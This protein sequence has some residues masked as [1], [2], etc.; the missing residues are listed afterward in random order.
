MS[1]TI[2][3][4]SKKF[5]DVDALSNI[6]LN[7]QQGELAALVGPSGCGKTTLL[8][9]IAGLEE[10]SSGKIIINDTVVYAGNVLEGEVSHRR[11]N[12]PISLPTQ[13][14]NLGM[15][16]QDFALWPHLTVFENVAFGLRA[17]KQTQNLD[18]RVSDALEQV[19]L[20]QFSQRFPSQLSGGQQQRVSI[21][22]AIVIQPQLIL[23]DEPLSALDAVLKD[24]IQQLLVALLKEHQL[25]AVYVTHDQAEAMSMADKVMILNQGKVEQF[26]RPEAIYHKPATEFVANFIGKN[27]RLPNSNGRTFIRMEALKF[28]Q[29]ANDSDV[30]F[31]ASIKNARFQGQHYLIE[32]D[33]GGEQWYF[34][35]PKRL[36]AGQSVSLYCAP[37]HINQIQLQG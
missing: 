33:V 22:R 16:F 14:R 1:L 13:Q 10:P 15:V 8:R 30:R 3:K 18:K 20:S 5:G 21:A 37:E 19:Q 36:E 2:Q 9:S 7:L 24:Q 29:A 35:A 6:D 31:E 32:A 4:I 23:L 26:D 25:T 28:Q 17:R 34:C 11:K 12:K 27:N